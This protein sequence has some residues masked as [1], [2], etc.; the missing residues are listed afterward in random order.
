MG[1]NYN[2][3]QVDIL[4]EDSGFLMVASGGVWYDSVNNCRNGNSYYA[5]RFVKNDRIIIMKF[6]NASTSDIS[7]R[8]MKRLI[9]P[10]FD[11][12]RGNV[13][14]SKCRRTI[15]DSLIYTFYIRKQI[16]MLGVVKINSGYKLIAL[17]IALISRATLFL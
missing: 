3:S 17:V 15:T 8:W 13:R 9:F 16:Q 7:L 14:I 2:G 1:P 12:N 4:P 5:W 11:W 6:D 10:D